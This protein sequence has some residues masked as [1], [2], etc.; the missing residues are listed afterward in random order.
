MPNLVG[1]DDVK[2][3]M[4]EVDVI[5]LPSYYNEG[6]PLSLIEAA[7]LELPMITTNTAGCREIV[8]N[9]WNGLLI[10][11]N[12]VSA[13]IDAMI[14]MI[15][16]PEARLAMGKNGRKLVLEKFDSRIVVRQT[17]NIYRV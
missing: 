10:P 3:I 13:L 15:E 9:N 16:N 17:V 8:K 2:N 7:S 5:V 6:V 14:W 1:Y 11:P 12:D 4:T